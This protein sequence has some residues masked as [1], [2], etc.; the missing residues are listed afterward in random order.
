MAGLAAAIQA[1]FSISKLR[2]L[3]RTAIQK[4]TNRMSSGNGT[5]TQRNRS[6]ALAGNYSLAELRAPA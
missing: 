1:S 2:D 3:G 4:G 6:K 5:E